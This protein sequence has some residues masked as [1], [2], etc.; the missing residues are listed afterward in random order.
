MMP[1]YPQ[2]PGGVPPN[3]MQQMPPQVPQQATGLPQGTQLQYRK[4][5]TGDG[6]TLARHIKKKR[7]TERNMP[8]KIDTFVPE[9]KLYT[10]LCEFEKKI[11]STIMRKR[12]DIQEAVGKPTKTMRTLRIFVSN[13]AADQPS[14]QSSNDMDDD[15]LDLS[16][17]SAPS[18][19]LRLEGRLLDPPIPTKK[20]QP[21]QKFTSFF[22]SIV[23]KL[24][25]NPNLYPE[26]NIIEWQ[27]QPGGTD[28]DGIEIKRKGDTTVNARILLELDYNPPKFKLG[29]MLC[30][31]LDMKLETK[32]QIMIGIWKYIQQNKLQ[33]SEDKRLVQCDQKLQ[34]LFG[35]PQVQFSHIPALID[36]H[37]SR[38]DPIVIDYTIRVDREFYQ[39]RKAYDIDVELDSLLKQKMMTTVAGTN[40]QKEILALDDKIVQCVQSINNSKI[41]RDFLLQFAGSPVE[42]INKWIASQARDL[43]IILGESQVNLEEMRQ[44]DFYKQPWVK[45][46]VFHYLTSKTQQRMQELL[47]QQ[48]RPPQ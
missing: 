48:H 36:Q 35:M 20:A 13:T 32:P 8:A 7:P 30:D 21:V 45:E 27:K 4:R 6:D 47:N 3:M 34:Q 15:G 39:S 12:L 31:M 46:A 9:S 43:E 23:V 29:P 22:R 24:D 5:P 10:E 38:P 44:S 26:G 28:N 19:T 41:K 14:Q 2:H 42:F 33:G 17:G 40:T 11:D 16:S 18:W 25:R 37:L 1:G